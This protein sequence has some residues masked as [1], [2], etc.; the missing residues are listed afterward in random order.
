MTLSMHRSE[1]VVVVLATLADHLR[2]H[3]KM[4]DGGTFELLLEPRSLSPRLMAYT[5]GHPGPREPNRYFALRAKL[6]AKAMGD[7]ANLIALRASPMRFARWV[8]RRGQ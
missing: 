1:S 6:S 5:L 8:D 2:R 3:F 7:P 4:L